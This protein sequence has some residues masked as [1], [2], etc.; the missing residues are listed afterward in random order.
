MNKRY[1]KGDYENVSATI[2]VE[3]AYKIATL[4]NNTKV[5]A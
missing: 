2:G 1:V 4:K 5:K 3:F